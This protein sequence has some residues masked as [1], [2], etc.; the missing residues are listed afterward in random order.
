MSCL[1][2]AFFGVQGWGIRAKGFLVG[3]VTPPS[4][5]QDLLVEQV[6]WDFGQRP[7]CCS[8][9]SPAIHIIELQGT[10]LGREA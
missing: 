1:V 6:L 8:F 10:Y 4:G 2:F 9:H 3:P 7:E 5:T